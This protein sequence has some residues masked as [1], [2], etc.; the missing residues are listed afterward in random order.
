[1]STAAIFDFKNFNSLTM[2]R[3]R[4]QICVILS[5]SSRSVDS[6]LK[7]DHF[8]F[9][10]IAAASNLG[11]W[12]FAIINVL[13][14]KKC[15]CAAPYVKLRQNRSNVCGDVAILRFSSWWPPPSWIF[16]KFNFLTAYRL[17]LGLADQVCV[18]LPNFVKIGP[19]VAEIWRIFDFQ[20][21]GCPLFWICC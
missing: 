2:V 6:L 21:G 5:I 3:L 16:K 15:Q 13:W 19:S 10:K 14:R 8:R 17:R 7:C 4:Y 12:E 11:F 1:M 20:D 18:Y 9:F